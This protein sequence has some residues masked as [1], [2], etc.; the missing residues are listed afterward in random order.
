MGWSSNLAGFI[1][2]PGTT[3]PVLFRYPARSTAAGIFIVSCGALAFGWTFAA[4]EGTIPSLF[5]G[6]PIFLIGLVMLGFGL[7]QLL[8]VRRIEV[9]VRAR[10]LVEVRRLPLAR[11]DV[12]THSF[13]SLRRIVVTRGVS[14]EDQSVS[15]TVVILLADGG[16]VD[17]GNYN[18]D[19]GERLVARLHDLTGAS[20]ETVPRT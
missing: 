15:D 12:K 14:T 7:W 19:K 18:G 6:A 5:F 11:S 3:D 2:V 8:P 1:E 13:E 9:H 4:G 20:V 10:K 17:L 16:H